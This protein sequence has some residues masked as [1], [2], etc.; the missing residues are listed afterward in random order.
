MLYHSHLLINAGD[1]PNRPDWNITRRWLRN[2]YRVHQ[3]LCMAFPSRA[4]ASPEE[5]RAAYCAP[6]PGG[7]PLERDLPTEPA[8]TG[9]GA[10]ETGKSA[11]HC[12]RDEEH[13]FLFRIDHPV[14]DVVDGRATRGGHPRRR[15][16]IVVQSGTEPDWDLAFGL[17]PGAKDDRGR[18]VGNT[19]HLLAGP[20]QC[21]KVSFSL[22][23]NALR[24]S[25]D[26]RPSEDFRVGPGDLVR[27]RL[28]ANPCVTTDGKRHRPRVPEEDHKAG[29]ERLAR[30]RL[31]VHEEWLK[32]RLGGAAEDVEVHTFVPGWAGAWRTKHEPQPNQKM[33]FWSVLFEG[34]FHVGD[35]AKLDGLLKKGVG[36]AKA[37]GFGL[38]SIAPA[39]EH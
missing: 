20:P 30:A 24:L 8:A 31:L 27:F 29:G 19:G 12:G 3:R 6:Y 39:P 7:G 16:V 38:L 14:I 4:P 1:N 35:P 28:R 13:G 33:Q 5:R 22:E 25:R 23:G 11:V 21:R 10:T 9:P 37:F 18:P 34:T 32:R 26:D 15:P 2:L 36:P 17:S